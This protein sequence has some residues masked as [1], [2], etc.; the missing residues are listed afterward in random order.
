MILGQIWSKVIRKAKKMKS[1]L[2]SNFVALSNRNLFCTKALQTLVFNYYIFNVE[3]RI[4]GLNAP[5]LLIEV[6]LA[7]LYIYIQYVIYI[8]TMYRQHI[9]MVIV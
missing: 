1:K 4:T 9:V 2:T 3:I 5:V 8:H 6:V 7:M